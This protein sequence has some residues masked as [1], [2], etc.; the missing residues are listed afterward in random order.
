MSPS[1]TL[2]ALAVLSAI[3]AAHA[4]DFPTVDAA[5]SHAVSE[6]TAAHAPAFEYAAVVIQTAE[7][8]RLTDLVRGEGDSFR[9]SLRLAAGEHLAA[10]FHTHPGAPSFSDM[11]SENDTKVSDQLN[12]PSYIYVTESQH[13]R[14]Y[15]PKVSPKYSLGAGPFR[16]T[17]ISKGA[18][19]NLEQIT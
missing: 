1:K 2:A 18:L 9:L 10:L 13:V 19:V 6:S 8:Y 14:K 12:V 16:N 3:G 15:I 7:G 17:S 4:S 11:F 5:I